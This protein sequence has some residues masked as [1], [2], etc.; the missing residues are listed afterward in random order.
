M[1]LLLDM[2]VSPRWLLL[3]AQAGID[4]VHWSALG[5]ANATDDEIMSAARADDR[6]VFTHDL[7]FGIALAL[8]GEAGPSVIQL[9]DQ[10]LMGVE[11]KTVLQAIRLCAD[12]LRAG[13]LLTI[14]AARFRVTLLPLRR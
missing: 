5:R 13:A 3:F 1:K 7:D 4:A 6:A 8:S 12:D 10:D 9:R 2:N 14:D 11:G